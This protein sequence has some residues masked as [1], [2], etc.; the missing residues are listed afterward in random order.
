MPAAVT[1][2]TAVLPMHIDSP[3]HDN[4]ADCRDAALQT[5]GNANAHQPHTGFFA[6]HK[7]VFLHLED[8]KLAAE[9][10]KAQHAG[11]DLGNV[12]RQRRAEH[13]EL[14]RNDEQQVQSDVQRTGQNQEVKRRFAVAQG[15]HDSRHHVVQKDEWD[16]RE[17][18]ANIDDSTV[19]N[20]VGGLHQLHHGRVSATVAMVST[21]LAAMQSQAALAT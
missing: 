8:I 7:V 13:A 14:E 12:G 5:H 20:I 18:P 10:D 11:N 16:A 9:V 3:L 17:N 19:D 15:T 4:A 21:T 2:A 1:A 6:E